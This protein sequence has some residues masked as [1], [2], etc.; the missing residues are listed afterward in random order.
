MAQNSVGTFIEKYSI[1]TR[2]TVF[3]ITEHKGHVPHFDGIIQNELLKVQFLDF[4][5][6]I[7]PQC[8]EAITVINTA[9]VVRGIVRVSCADLYKD[10]SFSSGIVT[11]ALL[12]TIVSIIDENSD[13]LYVQLPDGYLGWVNETVVKADKKKIE[14]WSNPGNLLFVHIPYTAVFD[15]EL[16]TEYVSEVSMGNILLNHGLKGSFYNVE[17]PDCRRGFISVDTAFTFTTWKTTSLLTPENIVAT[18]KRLTG[19]P[20]VW[21]GCSSR[22]LD[23]SGFTKLTY[24]MNGYVLP[25][26]AD[27]QAKTGITVD[28]DVSYKSLQPG[29]LLFFGRRV[30]GSVDKRKNEPVPIS[31]VGISLGG[32][33]YMQASGDVHKS[34]L[35]KSSSYFDKRRSE[36]LQMVKRIIQ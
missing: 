27:Q 31:H 8:T 2:I 5:H 33:L 12:G 22:G 30:D 29:D 9:E 1:D 35:D 3:K 26:D 10:A 32:S 21:G 16:I 28:Y 13:W 18:A 15:P 7:Y 34:S 25:R 23:C 24:L 6:S 14:L 36:S 11:Q 20:Y 17:F 4:I 19:I